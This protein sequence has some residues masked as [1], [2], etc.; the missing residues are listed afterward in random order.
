MKSNI[1]AAQFIYEIQLMHNSSL[2]FQI[3]GYSIVPGI[4]YRFLDGIPLIIANIESCI[5]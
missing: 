3:T 2:N 1:L 5:S 4:V